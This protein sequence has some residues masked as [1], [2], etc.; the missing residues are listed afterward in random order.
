MATAMSGEACMIQ[1]VSLR[2]LAR[3]HQNM[4]SL[5]VLSHSCS[6]GI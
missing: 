2:L 3:V 5:R 6:S 4:V 1:V